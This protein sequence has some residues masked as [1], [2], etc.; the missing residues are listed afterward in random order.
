MTK[1]NVSSPDMGWS[2]G[3]DIG[4]TF[5]DCAIVNPEGNRYISKVSSTPQRP[6][7][8][9]MNAVEKVSSHLGMDVKDLLSKASYF[10]HGTTVATNAA[11]ERKGAR[12]GF[13]TTKGFGDQVIIMGG[14]RGMGQELKYLLDFARVRQQDPLV[15]HEL[16]VEVPERVDYQGRVVAPIDKEEAR[17]VIRQLVEKNVQTIAVCLLWS[18]KNT[19]HEEVIR[20]L[21]AQ[22]SPDTFVSLSHEVAPVLGEYTRSVTTILNA[23]LQPVMESYIDELVAS[24]RED[25]FKGIPTILQSIGGVVPANVAV[26]RAV[27]TLTSGPVGGVL[28]SQHLGELL[29]FHNII[30]TDMG[31]T[32]FDAGLIVDGITS[33]NREPFVPEDD[34]YK[35]RYRILAP[36]VDI[37]TVGAGGGSIARIEGG[38][39]Q[40]G[41]ESA[42]AEPGPACY[43]RGGTLPT[44]TDADVV[45]GFLDP[46]NFLGGEMAL[47]AEAARKA[48]AE[49]IADPMGTDVTEA[50]AGISHVVEQNMAGL[51]RSITL[52]K[53]Y[54]PRDFVLFAYGGA[55]PI[56]CVGYGEELGAQSIVV[57]PESTVFS[58]LGIGIADHMYSAQL[59]DLMVLPFD[60]E[61][62][63]SN[64]AEVERRTRET[65]ASWGIPQKDIELKRYVDIRYS[66]QKTTLEIPVPDEP[67]VPETVDK[68]FETFKSKYARLY[69]ESALL[70]RFGFE[71]TN[72]KADGFGRRQ[73]PHLVAHEKGGKDP[74]PARR[75]ER[76]AYFPSVGDYEVASI[77]QGERLKAGNIITGPS[78][79]EYMGTTIVIPPARIAHV[80]EYLNVILASGGGK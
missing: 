17:H 40:V 20:E 32:S 65:I 9:V 66:G 71:V 75:G 13:I 70:E 31:G 15:P 34:P 67:L 52:D 2:V 5:T 16:T 39:L 59:S 14:D 6:L 60:L 24:L 78:I 47:N 36:M 28:A 41:P 73:K 77:Y 30:T 11:I 57:P 61:R 68:I 76:E 35:C 43:N 79:V 10:S 58:A 55:G 38:F 12:T 56:H 8:G 69:G 29:G 26:S 4:G 64:C 62:F 48:V 46:A 54:D 3:I 49:H 72:F 7:E 51:L 45:L 74:A 50:A 19:K 33:I 25:G 18:F 21:I 27:T 37:A 22:E 63:N 1:T 80:D 23:Y 53:G 42:G 44:V